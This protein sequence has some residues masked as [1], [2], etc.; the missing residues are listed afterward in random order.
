[1]AG[2]SNQV[3]ANDGADAPAE[4]GRGVPWSDLTKLS[5]KQLMSLRVSGRFQDQSDA[6]LQNPQDLG[7][8]RGQEPLPDDLTA[9][10][11]AQ[12]MTL[13]VRTRAPEP[14]PPQDDKPAIDDQ[15]AAQPGVDPQFPTSVPAQTDGQAPTDGQTQGDGQA[16]HDGAAHA[17]AGG[18]AAFALFEQVLGTEPLVLLLDDQDGE[19][20]L[21]LGPNPPADG[22]SLD[23]GFGSFDTP[24]G[25]LA[26]AV[27][28]TAPAPAPALSPSLA[29]DP[30]GSGGSGGAGGSG[31]ETLTGTAGNDTLTGTPGADTIHGLDGNDSLNGLAG[32]DALYGDGG[33]DTLYGGAGDDLLDG[34]SGKDYLDGGSGRDALYGGNGMDVLVWDANDSV[35]DG[36]NG[37]DTLL[38]NGQNIDLTAAGPALSNVE[39]VDLTAGPDETFTLTAR[40]LLDMT[41]SGHRVT[42]EGNAGD[43]VSLVNVMAAPGE[44]WSDDGVAGGYHVYS[45]T[46]DATAV[47]L[48]VD[49]EIAN[50]NVV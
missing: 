34:G 21:G 8:L 12:L 27:H 7:S 10:S 1:M 15:V 36:G 13:Q 24:G 48:M 26:A 33:H 45:A 19:D 35:I 28:Q 38:A 41:D 17:A 18:G 5:L 2:L 9:L 29:P 23:L 32:N 46:V 20:Q 11:L 37:P 39:T 4:A 31:G 42:V 6:A 44:N 50:Q 43:T 47:T 3:A 22:Y 30:G 25:F 49:T 40:D 14:D 16:Q